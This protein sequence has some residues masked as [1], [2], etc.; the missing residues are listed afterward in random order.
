MATV[1]ASKGNIDAVINEE[2]QPT[3]YIKNE[4][5]EPAD[6]GHMM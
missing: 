2:E 3:T 6:E 5:R 4:K 1:E